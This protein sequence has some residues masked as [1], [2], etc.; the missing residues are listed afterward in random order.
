MKFLAALE[1]AHEKY[2]FR[3]ALGACLLLPLKLS[4]AYFCLV[5]VLLLWLVQVRLNI[6]RALSPGSA[7]LLPYVFFVLVALVSLFFGFEPLRSLEKLSGVAFFGLTMLAVR[8]L[9]LVD[10]A[11]TER[12]LLALIG[13]QSIAAFYSVL[14]G[15]FGTSIPRVLVGAVS[16]SGQLALTI[17]IAC[18]LVILGARSPLDNSGPGGLRRKVDCVLGAFSFAAFTMLAFSSASKTPSPLFLVELVLCALL[19]GVAVAR[20]RQLC[21]YERYFSERCGTFLK[22]I[23]LPLLLAAL[24]VNLKRGP[25]MGVFVGGMLLLWLEHRRLTL[26]IVL[27]AAALLSTLK[28][29]QDR[30]ARSEE[31]FF[32]VGGRS[33]I[34]DIGV[35]LAKRFPLGVGYRNSFVLQKFSENVPSELTHFHNNLLNIAVEVGWLGLAVFLWWIFSLLRAA[36]ASVP[37]RRQRV[38]R[39][40]LGCAIVSWQVAGFVEYNFGDSEVV[41]VVLIVVGVLSALLA[42]AEKDVAA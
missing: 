38:L 34:W 19:F 27:V 5:P 33:E 17:P 36:F 40:S 18:G 39:C 30:L 10:P 6:W 29:V 4:I 3:L 12:V 13:G 14:E 16:E 11:R 26:P 31:H 35:E 28:P 22:T 7:V 15:A 37:S 24:L 9:C 32:I 25:W 20:L 1:S 23:A 21:K 41:L 42:S 8:D 2:S